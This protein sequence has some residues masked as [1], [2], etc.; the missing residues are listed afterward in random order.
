MP[1]LT[2]TYLGIQLRSPLVASAGPY[3]GDLDRLARIE[4]AGA[5]AVVLPSLWEEQI[6]HEAME[7]QRLYTLTTEHYAESLSGYFPEFDDY[8]TREELIAATG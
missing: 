7:F 4:D 2:T 1:E 5:G 3:T 8:G 6:E